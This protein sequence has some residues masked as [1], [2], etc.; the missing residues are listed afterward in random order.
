MA[1]RLSLILLTLWAAGPV[2]AETDRD[3]VCKELG[4]LAASIMGL[5]QKEVPLSTV[6]DRLIKPNPEVPDAR[7]IIRSVIIVA[8]AWPAYSTDENRSGAV[9]RYR[10]EVEYQCHVDG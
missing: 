3:M 9:D 1:K 4:K 10:N 5:R 7:K 6:L 8:Y 2:S